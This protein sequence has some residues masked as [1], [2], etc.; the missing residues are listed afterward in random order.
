MNQ[1]DGRGQF[2]RYPRVKTVR[3]GSLG[4]VQTLKSDK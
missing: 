4:Y 1:G 3:L 2:I